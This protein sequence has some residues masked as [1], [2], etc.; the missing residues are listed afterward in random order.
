MTENLFVYGTLLSGLGHPMHEVLDRYA[1]FIN[2]GYINGKLYTVNDYPGLILSNNSRK[3]VWGE[4]YRVDNATVVF[5]LLDQY[6][7][8]SARSPRPYEYQRNL[9]TIQDVHNDGML[10]W[11]YLYKRPVYHGQLIPAGDYLAFRNKGM[12]KIVNG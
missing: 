11:C 9:V 4:I 2:P 12:Q 1:H 5:D 8:C 10:A 3:V 6:E 7:G